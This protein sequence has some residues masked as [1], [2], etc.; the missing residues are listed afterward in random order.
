MDRYRVHRFDIK[1]AKDRDNLER[2]LNSLAGEVVAI[3]PN[4]KMKFFWVHS[5]DFLLITERIPA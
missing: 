4:V 1:M 2:F 5:I 3:T